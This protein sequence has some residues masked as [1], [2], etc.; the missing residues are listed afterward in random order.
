MA[1]D[2]SSTC[3]IDGEAG[4]GART[5]VDSDAADDATETTDAAMR[6]DETSRPCTMGESVPN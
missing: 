5:P 6:I 2:V 1:L 3:A 4:A